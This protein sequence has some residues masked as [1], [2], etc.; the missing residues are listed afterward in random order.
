M[1]RR[2]QLELLARAT[3]IGDPPDPPEDLSSTERAAWFDLV[4]VIKPGV[5]G[6]TDGHFLS[7]VAERVALHRQ[8][9]GTHEVRDLYRDLSEFCIEMP[10]RRRVLFPDRPRRR[11]LN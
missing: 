8:L 9:S 1:N 3:A 6:Q 7:H 11:A 5:L 4:A 10:A 2:Q